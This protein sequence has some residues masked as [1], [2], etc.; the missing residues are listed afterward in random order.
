MK[1]IHGLICLALLWL[2]AI[3][4]SSEAQETVTDN[5][6]TPKEVTL[7]SVLG[8]EKGS[9]FS[10][11]V[12]SWVD[13]AGHVCLATAYTYVPVS[14]NNHV[15]QLA[16]ST[17]SDGGATWSAGTVTAPKWGSENTPLG[18]VDDAQ[19][20]SVGQYNLVMVVRAWSS[21]TS[22]MAGAAYLEQPKSI[23]KKCGIYLCSSTDGGV[24]WGGWSAVAELS[25]ASGCATLENP[26]IAFRRDYYFVAGEDHLIDLVGYITWERKVYTVD[27]TSGNEKYHVDINSAHSLY[28]AIGIAAFNAHG[29]QVALIT[30][31]GN[32]P[33]YLDFGGIG[34]ERPSVAIAPDN[35]FWLSFYTISYPSTPG[36]VSE[37]HYVLKIFLAKGYCTV[38]NGSASFSVGSKAEVEPTISKVTVGN[39]DFNRGQMSMGNRDDGGMSTP[40]ALDPTARADADFCID[41]MSGPSV[42][43]VSNYKSESDCDYRYWVGVAFVQH[44]DDSHFVEYTNHTKVSFSSYT[45]SF[46]PSSTNAT[47]LV[48][49]SYDDD[50]H[51]NNA[52]QQGLE[53]AANLSFFPVLKWTTPEPPCEYPTYPSSETY[54]NFYAKESFFL[55]SFM[56]AER[57][58]FDYGHDDYDPKCLKYCACVTG[59]STDNKT[60]RRIKHDGAT[61]S[62][63]PLIRSAEKYDPNDQGLVNPINGYWGTKID[64][65]GDALMF[66]AHP[67]WHH[68]AVSMDMDHPL[69]ENL[70]EQS[71]QTNKAR[72][73]LLKA[74]VSNFPTESPINMVFPSGQLFST[75]LDNG[76]FYWGDYQY[77]DF[78][79]HELPTTITPQSSVTIAPY[80]TFNGLTGQYA[81]LPPIGATTPSQFPYGMFMYIY[82]SAN[83]ET[84]GQLDFSD[85]RKLVSTGGFLHTVYTRLGKV[86]Y[87]AMLPHSQGVGISEYVYG[88]SY[89]YAPPWGQELELS[90][91]G[92]R[93]SIAVYQEGNAAGDATQRYALGIVWAEYAN[94]TEYIKFRTAE[95]AHD[96]DYPIVWSEPYVIHSHV[97]AGGADD[98]TTPV[99]APLVTPKNESPA[100]DEGSILLGWNITWSSP[101][102]SPP[103]ACGNNSSPFTGLYSRTWLRWKNLTV[104]SANEDFGHPD[105]YAAPSDYSQSA[106]FQ[107]TGYPDALGSYNTLLEPS[108][109]N[110]KMN[111]I[112]FPTITSTESKYSPLEMPIAGSAPRNDYYDFNIGFTTDGSKPGIWVINVDYLRKPK[113]GHPI[114]WMYRNYT[115]TASDQNNPTAATNLG[116][117]DV[118]GQIY[119]LERNPSITIN[120]SGVSFV[121]WERMLDE[122]TYPP[123]PAKPVHTLHSEIVAQGQAYNSARWITA[124]PQQI[125]F[126]RINTELALNPRFEWLRNPSINGFPRTHLPDRTLPTADKDYGEVDFLQWIEN[127]VSLNVETPVDRLDNW[128]YLEKPG[129]TTKTLGAW[130]QY[131]YEVQP[132]ANSQRSV[133]MYEANTYGGGNKVLSVGGAAEDAIM[134]HS[135]GSYKG[136]YDS[137]LA[138]QVY[139]G[140]RLMVNSLGGRFV[141]GNVFVGDSSASLPSRQVKMCWNIDSTTNL[142]NISEVRNA[143]YR[144]ETFDYPVGAI[145]RYWRGFL[146]SDS[147]FASLDGPLYSP[148]RFLKYTVELV[149][150]SIHVDTLEQVVVAPYNGTFGS[151]KHVTVSNASGI[152]HDAYLRV[153][154]EMSLDTISNIAYTVQDIYARQPFEALFDTS[155]VYFKRGYGELSRKTDLSVGSPFPQPIEMRQGTIS[156]PVFY[157]EGHII[158]LT[159]VDNLGKTVSTQSVLS[160]GSWQLAGLTVPTSPGAYFVVV[161]A[162]NY[163]DVAPFI[164]TR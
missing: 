28:T 21:S 36:S 144:T 99:L 26:R 17:S 137:L 145:L 78:N 109:C 136:T 127:E 49:Q 56:A 82:K 13:N 139:S 25:S 24:S 153:R 160:T 93:P 69:E 48:H 11:S 46:D 140:E 113:D 81:Y 143:L 92:M 120:S 51:I 18:N 54:P 138:G 22:D 129:G 158:T 20:V 47:N 71:L 97:V 128:Y 133:G 68:I 85:Q 65:A 4:G 108:N 96:C 50:V 14:P 112:G 16:V 3:A 103:P 121:A 159:M 12:V 119:R 79:D 23:F 66:E 116:L 152:V 31:E 155:I 142:S 62:N 163:S 117:D 94:N 132:A 42:Q 131:A 74:Y 156:L 57:I 88:N 84:Q 45:T 122:V 53:H 87:G 134:F 149:S 5:Y 104:R 32:T 98:G 40:S 105:A 41:L 110:D 141:W 60:F 59:L 150:D 154:V 95:Y 80:Q 44:F 151:P 130:S 100:S 90:Q 75:D 106:G 115:V 164:V 30:T 162:D 118:I 101:R 124:M 9:A 15:R 2:L 123:S 125:T 70:M 43:T 7:P 58:G 10:P 102:L 91:N 33:K 76:Q 8:D 72:G 55:I 107:P 27:G 114:G 147:I 37:E 83:S 52:E 67:V 135:T 1:S 35:T 39:Y 77:F 86:Y 19:L 29:G 89:E 126:Q 6:Q 63:W 146:F 73:I 64:V 148:N 161:R 157:P 61:A 111:P 34:P 38:S